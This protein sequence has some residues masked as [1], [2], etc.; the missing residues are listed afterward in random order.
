MTALSMFVAKLSI[1]CILGY[2]HCMAMVEVDEAKQLIGFTLGIQC[3]WVQKS[4]KGGS[5]RETPFYTKRL[6]RL[7][8]HSLQTGGWPCA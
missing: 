4:R 7:C 8:L 2:E 1:V 3:V 5:E 6:E